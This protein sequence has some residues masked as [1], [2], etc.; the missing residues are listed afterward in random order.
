MYKLYL[1][2]L[3]HFSVISFRARGKITAASSASSFAP[4]PHYAMQNSVAYAFQG[5][6]K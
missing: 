5:G 4:L 3:T 2:I 6:R 1:R